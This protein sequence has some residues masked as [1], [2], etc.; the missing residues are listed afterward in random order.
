MCDPVTGMMAAGTLMNYQ[1]S[2]AQANATQQVAFNKAKQIDYQRSQTI[3]N[4]E[5]RQQQVFQ[6]NAD[7]SKSAMV[8]LAGSGID[9]SAGSS[10][11]VLADVMSA[12]AM[13]SM[14]IRA[15]IDSQLHGLES[16]SQSALTQ[17]ALDSSSINNNAN[18]SLLTSGAQT[19]HYYQQYK[20]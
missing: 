15:D 11:D 19:A 14:I 5:I 18:A 12:G 6:A 7:R 1:A 16:A 17:G 10:N 13:D 9:A 20:T 2:N 8:Q 4:G 3:K